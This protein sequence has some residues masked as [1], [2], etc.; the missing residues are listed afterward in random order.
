MPLPHM[1]LSVLWPPIRYSYA[2]D[3][4][5]ATEFLD[6]KLA[7]RV[8]PSIDSVGDVRGFRQR[9]EPVGAP[10]GNEDR[11]LVL[12][13]ELERER[14]ANLIAWRNGLPALGCTDLGGVGGV[15]KAR[16]DRITVAIARLG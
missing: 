15:A 10:R 11:V 16:E 5:Y 4:D 1:S 13:V 6:L 7:V 14:R 3:D 9:L 2:T 12:A 8:V